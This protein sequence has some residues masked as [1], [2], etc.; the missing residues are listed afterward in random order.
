LYQFAS[1]WVPLMSRAT[2][3]TGDRQPSPDRPKLLLCVHGGGF[4]V[5]SALLAHGLGR[6]IDLVYAII[7]DE[8]NFEGLAMPWGPTLVLKP[9]RS[10]AVRSIPELAAGLWANFWLLRRAMIHHRCEAVA[11]IG[12]NL[13][14]PAFLAARTCG[15]STIFIESLARTEKL[16]RTGSYCRAL[17]LVDRF[18]V[19][20]PALANQRR[21]ITYSGPLI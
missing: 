11:V 13:A 19:Q 3:D 8:V 7:P 21:R 9:V 12:S 20:W 2:S 4:V 1:N 10:E 16:S 6:D 14:L 17:R 15:R 18:Y 5:E